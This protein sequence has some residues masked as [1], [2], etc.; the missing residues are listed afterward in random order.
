VI[1]AENGRD[2]KINGEMMR[3]TEGGFAITEHAATSTV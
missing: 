1:E 2:A 3:D